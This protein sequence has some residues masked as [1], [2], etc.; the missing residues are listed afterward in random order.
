MTGRV[1]YNID[2]SMDWLKT[3]VKNVYIYK[4]D[5]IFY[6]ESIAADRALLLYY[7]KTDIGENHG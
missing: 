6:I 4:V 2:G 5:N 7:K 3:I 1:Y